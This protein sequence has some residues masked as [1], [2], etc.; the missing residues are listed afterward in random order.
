MSTVSRRVRSSSLSG[1]LCASL[2]L[3]AACSSGGSD[4][5]TTQIP[6]DDTDVTLSAVAGTWVVCNEAGGLRSEY[7]FAS[8]TYINRVGAGSCAGFASS[9]GFLENA[10]PYEITG[11]TMSDSGLEAY[12]MELVTETINGSPVFASLIETRYRLA[13]TGTADQL[14]FSDDTRDGQELSLTLN[15]NIPYVRVR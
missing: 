10:G 13:Y 1:A 8:D 5:N 14:F 11:T 6:A 15:L 9:D 7:V 2:L 12:T 3:L 4:N